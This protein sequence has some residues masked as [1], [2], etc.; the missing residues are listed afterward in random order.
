M[1]SFEISLPKTQFAV[2]EPI[3]L[4]MVLRNVSSETLTVNKR[5]MVNDAQARSPFRDVTL[6]IK[7]PLGDEAAFRFDIG[8]GFPGPDDFVKLAPGETF[9][10]SVNMTD[11]Y[12]LDAEGRYEVTAVY[13]NSVPGPRMFD[14]ATGTYVEGE[15]GAIRIK[16]SSNALV[17]QLEDAQH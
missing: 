9:E 17:F 16:R 4:T 13:Q 7:T 10:K 3:P 8:V 14:D 2:G 5:L 1:L 12:A 6:H 11:W 15:I